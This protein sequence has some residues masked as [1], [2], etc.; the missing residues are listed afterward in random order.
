MKRIALILLT[1]LLTVSTVACNKNATDDTTADT[2]AP[3]A[4][5]SDTTDTESE[6]ESESESETETSDGTGEEMEF[7]DVVSTVY[8]GLSTFV[9]TAPVVDESNILKVAL[10]GNTFTATGANKDWYRITVDDKPCYIST[11]GAIDK[12]VID[13]FEETDDKVAV[14]ADLLN[15]RALPSSQAQ[16]VGVVE[17]DTVLDRVAAT[18][19][20]SLVRFDAEYELEECYVSNKYLEVRVKPEGTYENGLVSFSY[21][22]TWEDM[23]SE[24]GGLIIDS[25]TQANI[26]VSASESIGLYDTMTK[27]IYEQVFVPVYTEMG[28]TI[29]DV[30][31]ARV[32]N[33]ND[34]N[35]TVITQKAAVE[36]ET[37]NSSLI[38]VTTNGQDVLITVT[39]TQSIS[40]VNQLIVDSVNIKG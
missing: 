14:T 12:N 39:S 3:I 31:V 8:V 20:W 30:A 32:T 4:V 35:V 27:E 24:D 38:V 6:T 22:P 9:R 7:D 18:E 5:G 19:D 1:L 17:K 37:V 25:T 2:T 10:K 26:Q 23:S 40:D 21:P 11:L 34:V 28:M 36:N 33:S 16:V 15:L 13:E 29:T